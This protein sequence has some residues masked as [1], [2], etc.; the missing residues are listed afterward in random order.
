MGVSSPAVS[1]ALEGNNNAAIAKTDEQLISLFNKFCE[2][3]KRGFSKESFPDCDH[4]TIE[5]YIKEFPAI[6]PTEKY[7][8]AMRHGRHFW[9]SVGMSGMMGIDEMIVNGKKTKLKSFHDAT[10]IFNMKNRFGWNDKQDITSGGRSFAPPR[11]VGI[12]NPHAKTD[13]ATEGSGSAAG[14]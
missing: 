11:K 3:L 6:L 2:H 8:E 10:W 1:K 5:K 14:G 7:N 9:E 13:D 12:K 4:R